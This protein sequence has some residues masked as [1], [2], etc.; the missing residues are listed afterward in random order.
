MVSIKAE[1]CRPLESEPE[2][3]QIIYFLESSQTGTS[4]FTRE[5]KADQ[6]KQAML[7]I[8]NTLYKNIVKREEL[9]I[10]KGEFAWLL[11]VDVLVFEELAL[12]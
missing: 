1:T 12:H 9:M 10:F 11:N 5:D 2:R 7:Q 4:L 8:L 6:T 3:G